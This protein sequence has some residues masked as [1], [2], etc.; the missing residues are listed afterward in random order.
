MKHLA[1]AIVVFT[2]AACGGGGGGGGGDK[3]VTY[4]GLTTQAVIDDTNAKTLAESAISGS[5]T[6]TAFGVVSEEQ[7]VQP[8]PTIL[9][10]ARILSNSV[11]QLDISPSSSILPGAIVTDSGSESCLDGGS[12]SFSLSV[13]DVTGDFNG[14][15]NFINCAEDGTTIHGETTISGSLE[16]GAFNLAFDPKVTVSSGTESYTMSGTV[17]ISGSED[18]ATIVMNVRFRNNNTEMVEWINN[19]TISVIDMGP[20]VEMTLTGR[21]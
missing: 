14:T 20:F 15:F 3:G 9:D 12:T 4:T 18:A 21:Y 6:G 11:T 8:N 2:L 19:V 1:L 16:T 13:D 17:K 7:E 10:V 5:S